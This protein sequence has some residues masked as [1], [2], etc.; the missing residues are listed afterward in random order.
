M[1][2]IKAEKPAAAAKASQT[3]GKAP[4]ASKSVPKKAAPKTAQEPKKK[5][6]RGG[7]SAVKAQ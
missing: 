2:S 5:V 1:A 4:P 6:A 3:T 7:K